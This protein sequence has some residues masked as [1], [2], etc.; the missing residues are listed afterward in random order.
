MLLHVRP[1]NVSGR[2]IFRFPRHRIGTATGSFLR[3]LLASAGLNWSGAFKQSH[4]LAFD[5][6]TIRQA[7]A[8]SWRRGM[9]P[10]RDGRAA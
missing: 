3:L 4:A 9:E 1:D 2:P 7:L 10:R 8:L 5:L 6:G